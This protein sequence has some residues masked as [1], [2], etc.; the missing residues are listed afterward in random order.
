MDQQK[1]RR[2][3]VL[4]FIC[5]TLTVELHLKLAELEMIIFKFMLLRS[6][7]MHSLTKKKEKCTSS[8]GIVRNF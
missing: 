1:L 5:Y 2:Y 6:L 4:F 7:I 3:K 8:L